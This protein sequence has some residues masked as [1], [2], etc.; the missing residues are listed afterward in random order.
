MLI[1]CWWK[2]RLTTYIVFPHAE[3]AVDFKPD[4]PAYDKEN[5]EI[6]SNESC[7]SRKHP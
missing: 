4:D 5:V 6:K 3:E 7:Y 1:F 2:I